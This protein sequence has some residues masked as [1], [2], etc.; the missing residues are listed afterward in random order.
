M[1]SWPSLVNLLLKGLLRTSLFSGL[2]SVLSRNSSTVMWVG[3]FIFL[4]GCTNILP[5]RSIRC[6]PVL[7]RSFQFSFFSRFSVFI[8]HYTS[9]PIQQFWWRIFP[10]LLMKTASFGSKEDVLETEGLLSN[11]WKSVVEVGSRDK[12]CYFR[13]RSEQISEKL[14]TF[15]GFFGKNEPCHG[16]SNIL[17]KNNP[18]TTDFLEKRRRLVFWGG[19]KTLYGL[20][21]AKAQ[22]GTNC[23][24]N[25]IR[26][27]TSISIW[28]CLPISNL[29]INCMVELEGST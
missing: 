11:I 2:V 26:I 24:T 15:W 3:R 4:F 14:S 20:I 1:S 28:C 27:Y 16:M 7:H 18:S 12:F 6:G 17:W 13:P 19:L 22:K 23:N 29:N 8:N 21:K 5:G 10:S 25:I 9:K